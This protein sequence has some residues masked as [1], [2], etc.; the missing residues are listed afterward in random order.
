MCLNT[1]KRQFASAC[2]HYQHYHYHCHYRSIYVS[3]TYTSC[4]QCKASSGLVVHVRVAIE[5]LE[6]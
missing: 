6:L 2:C 4:Q 1:S 5:K 3:L